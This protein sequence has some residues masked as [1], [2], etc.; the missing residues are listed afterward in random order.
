MTKEEK[1]VWR[2]PGA[3][4]TESAAQGPPML[5][6][7]FGVRDIVGILRRRKV[8]VLGWI[9]VATSLA[10]VALLFVSPRYTAETLVIVE[11]RDRN[12]AGVAAVVPGLPGDAETVEGEVQV[13]KSREL[14]E[15]VVIKLGLFQN[16]AFGG[17]PAW[18]AAQVPPERLAQA[19][20]RFR[21]RLR[22][23]QQGRSRVIAV[24]FS[25]V[26]AELAARVANTVAELY[27]TS[28]LESKYRATQS[29]TAW[30]DDRVQDL[31]AKVEASERAVEEFQLR[32]G[33]LQ[34]EALR[35]DLVKDLRTQETTLQR[36][37]AELTSEYGE[38]HP[39]L[40]S[41]RAELANLRRKLGGELNLNAAQVRLR[42]LEREA[43]SNRILLGT[44]L[45]RL[46][47]TSSQEDIKIQQPDAR[48][49]SAAAVPVDPSF[50]KTW[51]I[52]ALVAAGSGFAG[53]LV[54]FAAEQLDSGLRSAEEMDRI[55][56]LRSL[57][58]S[59]RVAASDAAAD[60]VG[61]V[62]EY[63]RSAYAESLRTLLWSLQLTQS[64]SGP[65]R[66]LVTSAEPEEGKTSVAA[67]LAAVQA[68]AGQRVLV[69]DADT[70]R[71]AVPHAFGLTAGSGLVEVLMEQANLDDVLIRDPRTG[72]ELLPAGAAPPDMPRWL[73]S[74]RMTSLLEEL[75]ARRYDLVIID[76]PP[77]LVAV[78]SCVLAGLADA[79]LLVVRWQTTR[80]EAVQAAVRQLVNAGAQLA[81]G[82]LT[83]VDLDRY[84]PYGYSGYGAYRNYIGS[85]YSEPAPLLRI[86]E[87]RD[88]RQS[89][90][91]LLRQLSEP[92]LRREF[93]RDLRALARRSL[94][95]WRS[96]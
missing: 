66:V 26:D 58:F 63:P 56:G 74:P 59:P 12:V 96:S 16:A 35:S 69:V 46:K 2:R 52:L 27:L 54:A 57:G 89:P 38:R 39:K 73:Q 22:V 37:L 72:V 23:I 1:I 77:V 11:S 81:G 20:D 4:G 43:E 21:D 80:R 88:L 14:A 51:L 30:L 78:D 8:L 29:A 82:V 17:S 32:S 18:T 84:A 15:R 53:V 87:W 6:A 94:R 41:L 67:C 62:L 90:E 61:Y 24:R 49:V 48:V 83:F 50:P 75:Q 40:V 3:P 25:S 5:P 79:T 76:A 13:L 92:R 33:L 95:K 10:A 7:G 28:Q 60:L 91:I 36:Q 71:P 86:R 45:A 19:V 93:V 47:E 68:K 31:S 9:F 55:E 65:R 42:A 64:D 44:Y 34:G 70:R 85:Y